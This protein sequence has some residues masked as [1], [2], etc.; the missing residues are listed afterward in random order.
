MTDLADRLRVIREKLGECAGRPGFGPPGPPLSES[1]V[2]AFESMHR[3]TLPEEYRAFLVGFGPGGSGPGDHGILPLS[4]AT[5][6]MMDPYPEAL[7]EEAVLDPERKFADYTEREPARG[8]VTL[9]YE[10][11]HETYFLLVV[12][13]ARRGRL[14]RFDAHFSL[15]VDCVESASGEPVG[16]LAWYEDYLDRLLAG[17]RIVLFSST[18]LGDEP[19]LTRLATDEAAPERL[20]IKAI[21]ALGVLRTASHARETFV[22]LLERSSS[23]AVKAY[24]LRSLGRLAPNDSATDGFARQAVAAPDA[25]LHE[26]AFDVATSTHRLDDV[27]FQLLDAPEPRLVERAFLA[28]KRSGKI[29][30]QI[31]ERMAPHAS[32]QVRQQVL[33]MF[34]EMTTPEAVNHII[35]A[36][37]DPDPAMR[38]IAAHTVRN[39]QLAQALPALEA[40]FAV[41]KDPDPARA[42]TKALEALR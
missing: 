39:R 20:R 11:F 19:S 34:G 14:C 13:G 7:A 3:V 38:R 4:R 36:L 16:F 23:P 37:H 42:M 33:T 5:D 41:E 24:A 8:T 29:T 9:T 26:A 22:L 12:S 15:Q 35:A 2:S 28:L 31:L 1:D 18:M 25:V 32:P 21:G 30:T 10:S 17:T 40:A 27:L 6:G